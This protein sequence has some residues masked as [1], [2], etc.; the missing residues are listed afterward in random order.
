MVQHAAENKPFAATGSMGL[1]G[2]YVLGIGGV[3]GV[4]LRAEF[5]GE[6]L[7]EAPSL[8][9]AEVREREW[10]L[11]G[12]GPLAA[13]VE[14]ELRTLLRSMPQLY[15]L[16]VPVVMVFVIGSLFRN[17]GPRWGIPFNWRCQCAWRTDCSDSRASSIT[18]WVPKAQGYRCCF[19]SPRR[20]GQ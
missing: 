14:K 13:V 8:K 11:N 18:T 9:K 19:F 5:R 10:L 1:L 7:G 16:G 2:L 15:A 12:A 17:G 3:L 4:R 6:N 20:S